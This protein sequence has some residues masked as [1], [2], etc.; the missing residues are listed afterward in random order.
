M[1][2][3]ANWA[4]AFPL[5]SATDAVTAVCTAWKFYASAPRPGFNRSTPEPK[6]T[7]LICGYVRRVVAHD[8]GLFGIWTAENV[9]TDLDPVTGELIQ[10]RRTDIQY[11]WNDDAAR[12]QLELV[13]EFKRLRATKSDRKHYL[14]HKGLQRFVTGIYSVGQE[15]AL[16][17]G[18]LLDSQSAVLPPLKAEF[19]DPALAT[20]LALAPAASGAPLIQPAA[21]AHADFDTEHIRPP[22]RGHASG[23]MK[24]SHM[25]LEFDYE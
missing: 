3:G 12:Q 10:E 23:R 9:I 14:G 16:M 25:F 22:P 15:R 19:A 11:G 5:K 2:A 8:L 20:Q 17:V 18:I 7:K 4:A 1:S 13:F 24:V 21:F 6:L